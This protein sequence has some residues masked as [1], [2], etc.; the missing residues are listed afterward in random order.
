MQVVTMLM[1]ATKKGVR[2][3]TRHHQGRKAFLHATKQRALYFL[4]GAE[5]NF[6][7][8]QTTELL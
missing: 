3:A 5:N 4:S 8:Y 7:S 6:T 2:C 1:S